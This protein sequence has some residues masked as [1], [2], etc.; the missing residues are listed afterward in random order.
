M[1][2]CQEE[3]I[4]GL[5]SDRAKLLSYI[6]AIVLSVHAAEDIHQEVIIQA[7]Q[8]ADT[9]SD[10]THLFA[11]ARHAAKLRA[12][13]Y[14]RRMQRQPLHIDP[15]VL[16]LLEPIWDSEVSGPSMM[17]A[18]NDCLQRMSSRSRKLINMRFGDRMSGLQMSQSLG[19]KVP[20][21]Y[22]AL[23]RLYRMLE[24]CI[25]RKLADSP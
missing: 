23:S 7:L 19:L 5:L 3:V 2:L 12:F 11:W 16:D 22:M 13:D 1:S 9:I 25:R 10:R 15:D 14:L 6:R 21:V 8:K 20:S 4:H 24:D 17:G 18:L